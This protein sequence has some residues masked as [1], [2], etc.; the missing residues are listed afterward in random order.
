MDPSA[1]PAAQSQATIRLVAVGDILLNGSQLEA[2][3]VDE[4]LR[5]IQPLIAQADIACA[6][7]ECTLPGSGSLIETEPRVIASARQI[8]AVKGCGF[9]VV[10]L[11]NNHMFDSLRPGFERLQSFLRDLRLANF[12][13]GLDLEQ[14]RAPLFR[15]VNGIRLGF[16]GAADRGSG[17]RHFARPD[18]WGVAP[19][20]LPALQAQIREL[21]R[22]CDHLVVSLHWG[23]ERFSIPAPRQIEQAHALIEAGAGIILGHHPHVLQ[24]YEIYRGKPIIYSLGNFI[25][26]DLPFSDGNILSW[27]GPERI[28]CILRLVLDREKVLQV[29]QIATCDRRPSLVITEDKHHLRYVRRVN[30][31]LARGITMPRYRWEHFKIRVC[32]PIWAHLRW[33]KL[34]QLRWRQLSRFLNQ[35]RGASPAG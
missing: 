19:L 24:G 2:T 17:I 22:Q 30:R 25:A 16:I 6:N 21:S 28:G 1:I 4:R 12:G 20:D 7:L 34:R 5:L 33:R 23:E 13:A 31:R 18:H 15:E 8:E 9:Q 11:A 26:D 27:K 3:A 29:E 32:Q 14:A 35:L 10:N